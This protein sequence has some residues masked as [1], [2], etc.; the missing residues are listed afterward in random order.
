[1][2]ISRVP[3]KYAKEGGECSFMCFHIWPWK[4]THTG[5]CDSMSFNPSLCWSQQQNHGM[6]SNIQQSHYNNFTGECTSL[7]MW[8]SLIDHSGFSFKLSKVWPCTK[9]VA[10]SKPWA[11]F[12]CGCTFVGLHCT[13]NGKSMCVGGYVRSRSTISGRCGV[14]TRLFTAILWSNAL[15]IIWYAVCLS[16]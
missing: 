4:S 8:S 5:Y 3:Y 11:L 7:A 15:D 13:H 2:P 12:K 9:N 1:M 16:I 14:E 6:K 10:K